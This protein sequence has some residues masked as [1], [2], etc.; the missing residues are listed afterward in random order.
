MCATLWSCVASALPGL[1]LSLAMTPA[2]QVVNRAANRAWA[3]PPLLTVVEWAEQ[4]RRLGG[5]SPEKGEYRVR[6]TPYAAQVMECLSPSHP[7]RWIIWKKGTQVGGTSVALNWLGFIIGHAPAPTIIT[8]P[9]E[10]VT[11]EWADQRLTQLVDETPA[12]RGKILDSSDRGSR[13]SRYLKR[14]AGSSATIKLAWSTSAKK[15]RSTPA[16]NLISDEADGFIGDV[17]GEGD[18][19]AL[20][21]RRFTNFPRGKHY[22]TS[23]PGEAPSRIDREFLKGDQRYYFVACPMCDHYQVLQMEQFVWPAKPA[24]ETVTAA[25]ERYRKVASRCSA[26]GGSIPERFKTQML[27]G[28]LWVATIEAP[29]MLEKGFPG[30]E[31][32]KLAPILAQM[33]V[34]RVASFDLSALYSPIGWYSWS[35]LARESEG[36][37]ADP[38]QLKTF[39]NTVLGRV[40]HVTGERPDPKRLYD[41]REKQHPIGT[42][43]SGG[44]MLVATV[45]QQADRLELEVKALG[46][47]RQQW[48]VYYE[49]IQPQRK[50]LFG[51]FTVCRTSEPE[52]WLR[53]AE[54][55]GAKWP[56]A[57][58]G[59]LEIM[60]TGIDTGYNPDPVYEFCRKYPQPAHGPAGS[61]VISYG[62]VVPIKGGHSAYKLIEN[63]SDTDAARKR[64]G[65]RIVTIGA[66]YA[67]QQVYDSLNLEA[68]TD[69][70]SFPPGY[71][72]LPDYEYWYFEGLTAETRIITSK[73]GIEW[74]KEGRNEPLDLAGYC[75]GIAELC[76]VPWFSEDDWQELERLLARSRPAEPVP[77][78]PKLSAEVEQPQAADRWIPRRN[79]FAR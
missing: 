22:I 25:L 77:A 62:T 65:L 49:V 30:R 8:L 52:P 44:L 5:D 43:P 39:Q 78:A 12:L 79:W 63:V 20:L 64:F 28:G 56:H 34:A 72:H 54:V 24:E 60:A 51:N 45:D 69:G 11:K 57:D 67:K 18:P 66:A 47:N 2:V 35:D 61:R 14:I 37:Q 15:L 13:N 23:T 74:H 70:V 58:G 75:L 42:V 21:D 31:R 59:F 33:S 50:D 41:R 3:P 7:A 76:G 55:I 40:S 73:G 19:L 32:N 17:E 9:S 1:L 10:A 29:D 6:R 48:S 71:Y 36:A 53:L 26:C 27:A 68:P 4:N 38:R 16:A 46:R